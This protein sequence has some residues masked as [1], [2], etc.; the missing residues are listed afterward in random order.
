MLFLEGVDGGVRVGVTGFPEG[1]D[2]LIALVVS[3]ESQKLFFF[4][5]VDDV[6]DVLFEPLAVML[7][8]LAS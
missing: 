8:E 1:F 5:F 2:E 6:G 7:R 3:F 4:V